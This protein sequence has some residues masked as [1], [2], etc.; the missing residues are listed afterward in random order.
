MFDTMKQELDRQMGL[1]SAVDVQIS[2]R[3]DSRTG[4]HVSFYRLGM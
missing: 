2:F 1:E 4:Y 3:G